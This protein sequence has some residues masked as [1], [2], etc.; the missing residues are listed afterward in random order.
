MAKMRVTL[1]SQRKGKSGVF[2]AAHNDRTNTETAKHI[3]KE[4]SKDNIYWSW[5]GSQSFVESELKFYDENF[6]AGLEA[7]NKR[8]VKNRHP[9]RVQ[10][11]IDYY[12]NEAS[13]PDEYLL[14]VG[15]IK[16]NIGRKKLEKIGVKFWMFCKENYP[17]FKPLNMALHVDELGAP[18][19]QFRAAWIGH[20]KDGNAIVGQNKA[21]DEMG[22]KLPDEQK[23][24]SRYNNRKMIFTAICREKLQKLAR[25]EGFEIETEPRERSQSG[26]SLVE[27]RARQEEEKAKA[28]KAEAEKAKADAKAAKDETEVARAET[29]KAKAE[30]KAAKDKAA[31]T[32][33]EA[34]KV[35]AEAE[36]RMMD[37]KQEIEVAEKR[38]K[39]IVE[40]EKVK[41]KEKENIAEIER[42]VKERPIKKSDGFLGDKK[43]TGYE[44]SVR[45]IDELLHMAR[46]GVNVAEAEER[47]KDAEER[48][49][50]AEKR[51]KEA[52]RE[53][54]KA[55]LEL[56][57]LRDRVTALERRDNHA[58][59]LVMAAATKLAKMGDERAREAVINASKSDAKED[60]QRDWKWMTEA[61][62]DEAHLRKVYRDDY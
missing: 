7:K 22:F 33:A 58:R 31:A 14:Y 18:H 36:A 11:M 10:T 34:E 44:V 12:R 15:N 20:D 17:N 8:Y 49:K 54:A 57:P 16:N 37:I 9:E 25:E 1:H 4:K 24:K 27:Y 21:L 42:V 5:D 2:S 47:A 32:K 30:E 13:C 29:A 35:K 52:E 43:I 60:W 55:M 53:A 48:K 40:A 41:G 3:D 46:L 28:A 23:K 39:D 50:A 51:A 45:A 38:L 59:R 61:D 62:K 19:I 26:L 6:R 56:D